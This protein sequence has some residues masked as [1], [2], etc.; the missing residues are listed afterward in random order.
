MKF[1]KRNGSPMPSHTMEMAEETKS[2][3]MDRREFL[4]IASAFGATA[5]TAYGMIGMV[6]PTDAMAAE[7]KKGGILKVSTN[8]RELKDPRTFDWSEMGNLARQFLEPLVRY[9][10]DFTFE[11]RLIEGWEINDDATQYTLKVRKGIKWNNGDDFNAD[12]VIFNITRWCDKAVEGNS[13]AGRMASLIDPAT[14]KLG[15]G[16]LSKVDDHTVTINLNTADITIIPGMSDYPALIVHRDYEK[17]GSDLAKNPIGT[18]PFELESVEVGTMASVRRRTNGTWW[19]GEVYLD[20]VDFVDYGTDPSAE[21]SAFESEE[22]HTNYQTTADF[23]EIM[24]S[25]GL[26]KSEAVTAATVCVRTNANAKP[27]DDQ[28]V[29]RA[30]QIAVDNSTVLQLGYGGAGKVAE[31]HHVAPLHPEYFP[32]PK[33]TRDIEGAKKLMTEAGMMD[34]EHELLSIDDDYR[35]NTADAVAAQLREAGFKIKRTVLP[36]STFWND[37]AKYPYSITN[38]NMRPLGVQVLALAYR[39]GEAWN[40]A[41]HSN[42]E[43]DEKL[44]AALAVADTDKRR[45]MMQDIEQILQDSGHLVQ[46]YWRS[47]YNHSVESVKNHG[48]HPT[49][50]F[51]FEKVWLDE[52]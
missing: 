22:I 40:E 2:G 26:V 44:T 52:A 31:N 10:R 20:G 8:V 16:V 46:P 32:L 11:G 47:L 50:E 19:D 48:M 14:E 37:W 5:A 6:A 49:F 36:G 12:D 30:L 3:K 9:N 34:H 38:W 43:F 18:G 33:Q 21:V 13:M 23:L 51:H 28:R 39:S 1:F 4:A 24:D 25:L 35:K 27:Y 42:P 15:E 45:A 7:G 41:A 29:R 17:M